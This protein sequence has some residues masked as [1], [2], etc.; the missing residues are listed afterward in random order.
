MQISEPHLDNNP[1][2]YRV[3]LVESLVGI[4]PADISLEQAREERLAKLE[5]N[6]GS[7]KRNNNCFEE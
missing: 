6:R 5:Y 4:I 2:Q 3:D 7:Q 1:F